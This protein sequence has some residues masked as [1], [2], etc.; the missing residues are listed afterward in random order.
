MT[1]SLGCKASEDAVW[2]IE[3]GLKEVQHGGIYRSWTQGGTHGQAM[4]F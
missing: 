1:G 2:E 3:R 4:K